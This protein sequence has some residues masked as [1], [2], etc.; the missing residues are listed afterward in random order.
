MLSLLEEKFFLGAKMALNIKDPATERSVR[1]LAALTGE[2]VTTAVRK[3]AEERL[4]RVRRGG[5]P[6]LALELLKIGERC[7]AL[8]D[9][10]HRDPDDILGYDEHGLPR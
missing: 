7:A 5:G 1:E 8:P 6:S 2:G 3:A 9:L 10:D 4:Q